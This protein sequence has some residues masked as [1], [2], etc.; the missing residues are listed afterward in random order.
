M[1]TRIAA[2]SA[3]AL[4]LFAGLLLLASAWAD[5]IHFEDGRKLEGTIIKETP[6]TVT[7]KT[8]Y[9]TQIVDKME[10]LNIEKGQSE[11]QE[12]ETRKEEI[13]DEDNAEARYQLG[14][15]CKKNGLEKEADEEFEK[16]IQLDSE[17][18][19][20]RSELGYQKHEGQWLTEDE[21]KEN[22]GFRKWQG[23]WVSAEDYDKRVKDKLQ[24]QKEKESKEAAKMAEEVRK[25]TEAAAKEYEG[26]PWDNRH[27]IATK[28]F[29]IECNSTKKIADKYAWLMERLYE[30]YSKVFAA[31]QPADRKCNIFIHRSHQEF[32]QIRRKPAGVG[33]FYMPGQYQLVGFHGAFGATS[34]TA[35]VLAHEGTHLFQDL[36]GMFGRPVRSPIWLI[37]GLAV[38]MEAA[39]V[40][41]KSGKISIKGV[42]R[43]R[44]VQLQ[45]ELSGKR[46]TAMTLQ[47]V[48][49]TAQ[50]AF[51]GRHYAYAGMFT[52][53]ML[54]G[55]KNKKLALLYNDYVKIGTGPQGGGRGGK[56]IQPNDFQ[57]LLD[58]H[59]KCSLSDLE[60]KWKK[61]VLKQ[62]P[63][64]LVYKR[65]RKYSCKQLGFSVEGPSGWKGTC[66]DVLPGEMVV[67]TNDKLDARIS[68]R[69][70]GNFMN[71]TLES[72]VSAIKK[73]LSDSASKGTLTDYKMVSERFDTLKGHKAYDY[74]ILAKS[75]KST[76]TKELMKR[77]TIYFV[78]PDNLYSVNLMAPPGKYD[79]CLEACL[80]IL[81]SFEIEL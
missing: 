39:E 51:T 60:E 72:L 58:K 14:L 64:R 18:K 55:S 35:T 70:S 9:G 3:A 71:Y 25:A 32:M 38:L 30:K 8:K 59:M 65:G 76:I 66:D 75:P 80:S 50:R 48:M 63:D 44:L 31:F 16:A 81:E 62:K 13:E 11:R 53:W 73:S 57:N 37:E 79:E 21:V 52:Y 2:K 43:D 4:V 10:I 45:A 77:R 67:F 26:V 28:H 12:Y 49:S 19:G 74:V 7:I 6:D 61:W 33:G 69:A 34:N 5:T 36:I 15:W 23:Q 54:Q 24:R 40:N 42:S 46:G 1:R 56:Q 17:H 47:Q 27:R 78:T 29:S 41:W 20:A 22:Q 68:V